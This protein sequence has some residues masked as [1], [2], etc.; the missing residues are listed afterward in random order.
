MT[1]LE[2]DADVLR[3]VIGRLQKRITKLTK[4]RDHYKEVLEHYKAVIG[5][6]WRIERRYSTYQEMLT[7]RKRI[8]ALENRVQEQA[9]L[10]KRLTT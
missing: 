5:G 1:T 2:T 3:V 9:E 10:I 4:Q 8:K 7:E 6:D